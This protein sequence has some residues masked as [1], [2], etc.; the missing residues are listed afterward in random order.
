MT[1]HVF[2]S[3]AQEDEILQKRLETHLTVLLQQGAIT[4]W[5]KRNISAGTE[6]MNQID[7]HIENAQIILLLVSAHFFASQYSYGSELQRALQ[8]HRLNEARVI[9]IILRS[10][11]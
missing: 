5:N 2:Y 1:I 4:A 9:P 11:D 8:R 3:Y 7:E 6:W 10:V